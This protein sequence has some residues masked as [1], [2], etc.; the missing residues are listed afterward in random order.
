MPIR[1]AVLER[2]L[3]ECVNMLSLHVQAGIEIDESLTKRIHGVVQHVCIEDR[4]FSDN[5]EMVKETVSLLLEYI[6]QIQRPHPLVKQGTA[7]PAFV[8]AYKQGQL[9]DKGIVLLPP[10]ASVT[11][12]YDE[13]NKLQYYSIHKGA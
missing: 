11:A 4:F 13:N 1:Q 6:E 2:R 3:S 8:L 5:A 12:C 10:T 9:K 7:S